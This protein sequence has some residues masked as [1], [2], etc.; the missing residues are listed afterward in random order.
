MTRNL[1]FKCPISGLTVQGRIERTHE[2]EHAEH[3]QE[4]DCPGCGA[5]H[6]INRRTG[7]VLGQK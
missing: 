7:K 4:V 5:A 6:F 1:L 2:G 3:Y